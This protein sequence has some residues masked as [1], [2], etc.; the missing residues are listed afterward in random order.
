MNFHPTLIALHIADTT[1]G[2][3]RRKPRMSRALAWT[4]LMA[5]AS[6]LYFAGRMA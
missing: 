4:V 6:V 3:C 1:N 5:L 2:A